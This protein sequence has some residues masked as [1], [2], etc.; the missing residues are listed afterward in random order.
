VG[1]IVIKICGDA[2]CLRDEFSQA[3]NDGAAFAKDTEKTVTSRLQG[4]FSK[5]GSSIKNSLLPVVAVGAII[6]KI[7]SRCCR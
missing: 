3:T 5:L 1:E 2:Q 6:R 7:G 4:A